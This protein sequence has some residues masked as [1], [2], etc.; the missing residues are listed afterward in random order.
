MANNGTSFSFGFQLPVQQPAQPSM[1]DQPTGAGQEEAYSC[2]EY[3]APA[4]EHYMV[5]LHPPVQEEGQ[6]ALESVEI[7]PGFSLLKGRVTGQ[8][9]SGNDPS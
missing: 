7:L 9:A 8:E 4:Q 1:H 5:S 6:H 2:K 3:N